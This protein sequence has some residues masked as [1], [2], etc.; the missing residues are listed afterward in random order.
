MLASLPLSRRL[1]GLIVMSLPLSDQV[2]ERLNDRH[3]TTVLVELER[4]GFSAVAIDNVAGG[5]MVAELLVRKAHT[6]FGF[7]GEGGTKPHPHDRVLQAEARMLGFRVALEQHGCQL[8]DAGVRLVGRDLHWATQAA[9]DLLDA[10]ERP[11]AIFAHDDLF[12]SG[13]LRA[14][15]SRGIRVPEELAVVGFDDSELAEHLELTSVRATV[16]GVRP[17]RGG[18]AARS[19]A[20]SEAQPPTRHVEAH[21]R[22]A[23]DDVTTVQPTRRGEDALRLTRF[24]ATSSVSRPL[25]LRVRMW[26]KLAQW[27]QAV[28]VY[29]SMAAMSGVPLAKR[30]A[31]KPPWWLTRSLPA[32]VRIDD[33][34]AAESG[35]PATLRVYRSVDAVASSPVVLFTHGGG[36]VTGGLDAMQFL[37]AQVASTAHAVVVSVDYPL[38]PRT[39][40]PGR[41]RHELRGPC[42]GRRPSR[43]SRRRLESPRC[44]GRQRRRESY[45][46]TLSTRAAKWRSAH[47]T[48]GAH[49]PSA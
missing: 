43:G 18:N 37:C 46:G 11:T 13:V 8:P 17:S 4:P 29:P 44:H 22:R 36:F 35:P 40:L 32:D 3:L 14:A 26:L 20:R 10:E 19:A 7:V 31:S 48:T 16:R 47:R 33:H 45:S 30:V 49:L 38:A 24:A 1:D 41:T 5:S 23:S 6:R 42:L 28:G 39:S 9:D 15:R 25:D 21:A 27:L 2:T 34:P 12:A